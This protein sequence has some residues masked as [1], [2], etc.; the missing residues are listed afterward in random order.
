[1]RRRPGSAPARDHTGAHRTGRVLA[2]TAGLALV[3]IVATAP[4]FVLSARSPA[5]DRHDER[6]A[7]PVARRR[8]GATTTP[9]SR[10]RPEPASTTTAPRPAA[11]SVDCAAAVGVG[12]S[13]L[14]AMNF[15]GRL[16]PITLGRHSPMANG[17]VLRAIPVLAADIGYR[18]GSPRQLA[19]VGA[20][21]AA[22]PGV[23][24]DYF[25]VLG[26]NHTGTISGIP[27]D[28]RAWD[29][30][31]TAELDAM[32]DLMTVPDKRGPGGRVLVIGSFYGPT[33][34]GWYRQGAAD[35]DGAVRAYIA[36]HPDRDVRLVTIDGGAIAWA[37]GWVHPTSPRT[38]SEP[39]TGQDQ[40]MLLV[41]RQL[42]QA[43]P[44]LAAPRPG[45]I[46][47]PR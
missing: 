5:T 37:V 45:A 10:P 44:G 38:R 21:R 9:T 25:T 8:P 2:A 23:S 1:M 27:G 12:D 42:A 33:A 16:A 11:G 26:P 28:T 17:P 43:F 32:L 20:Q 7:P 19:F 47:G 24:R 18:Y 14:A 13:R 34:P 31:D 30:V 22:C 3:T 6:S 4:R 46:R 40:L 35:H 15:Q 36:A 41:A 29:P 39:M